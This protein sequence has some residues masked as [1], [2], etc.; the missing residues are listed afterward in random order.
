MDTIER[1]ELR[2]ECFSNGN[3]KEFEQFLLDNYWAFPVQEINPAAIV[4]VPIGQ[5][6]DTD[7]G[8]QDLVFLD[9]TGKLYIIEC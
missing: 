9:D 8:P 6:V 5:Q 3:E 7:A 1:A 4:A 2:E